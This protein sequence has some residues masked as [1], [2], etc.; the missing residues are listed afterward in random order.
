M[1]SSILITG[2]GKRIGAHLAEHFAARGRSLVLHYHRSQHEA[3]ALKARLMKAHGVNVALVQADLANTVSL[4]D[5]WKNLPACDAFIHNAALF[6]RDMFDSFSA[7]SL[8]KNLAL[9]LQAPLILAQGF[10]KQLPNATQGSITILGDGCHGWSISPHFFSYA[11]SKQAWAGVIDLLAA[12]VA[13]RARA[14]VVALGPSLPGAMDDSDTFERLAAITPLQ[15]TSTPDEVAAAVAYLLA[16][17]SVTGQVLSLAA[18]MGLST[19]RSNK[20]LTEAP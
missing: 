15:R 5:F 19:A 4:G 11:V 10:V 13:P 6:E 1:T 8:S 16:A 2:A 20:T 9:H 7:A 18:G 17:P 3:E 12:A 14:N